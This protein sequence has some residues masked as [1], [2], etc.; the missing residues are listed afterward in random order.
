MKKRR[1]SGLFQVFIIISAYLLIF[2]GCKSDEEIKCEPDNYEVNNTLD[3]ASSLGSVKEESKTFKA[4]ISEEGDLDF[5]SITAEE[6]D[7]IGTPFSSQYFRITFDLLLPSDKDYDLYIYDENGSVAGQSTERNKNE[8][9]VELDWEGMI[10]VDDSR[11]FSI[12]VRPYSGAW[13][14]SDYTLKVTMSYSEAPW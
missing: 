5:Y 6:A 7:H 1:L 4:R 10:G 9:I 14:C 3:K 13:D 11:S 12:E 2:S 8:E